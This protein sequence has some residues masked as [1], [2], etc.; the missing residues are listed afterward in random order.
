MEEK[1][2]EFKQN[3]RYLITLILILI[4]QYVLFRILFWFGKH[5]ETP[6]LV[7]SILMN[8]CMFALVQLCVEINNK[9]NMYPLKHQTQK[10]FQYLVLLGNLN[11]WEEQKINIL[12]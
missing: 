1:F 8:I 10:K 9:V 3:L 11:N 2:S 7:Q 4:L 6:L 5:Y 12:L